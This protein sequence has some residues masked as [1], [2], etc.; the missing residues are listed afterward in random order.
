E[1]Q[2]GQRYGMALETAQSGEERR[3][4]EAGIVAEHFRVVLDARRPRARDDRLKLA[5]LAVPE[6]VW[7]LTELI[8]KPACERQLVWRVDPVGAEIVE[9]P[10]RV[11]IW[12]LH[13]V[14]GTHAHVKR[15]NIGLPVGEPVRGAG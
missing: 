10:V 4:W 7:G 8:W 3:A 15:H 1:E 6:G 9:F 12:L 14:V 13:C 2:I 5:D 11:G